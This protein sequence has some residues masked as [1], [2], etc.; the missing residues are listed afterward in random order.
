MEQ[1]AEK[2]N[3]AKQVKRSHYVRNISSCVGI[4][5]ANL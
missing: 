3:W 1:K 2:G 5:N 4:F